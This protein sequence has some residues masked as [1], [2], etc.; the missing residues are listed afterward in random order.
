MDCWKLP[1]QEA[2]SQGDSAMQ[3]PQILFIKIVNYKVESL[4]EWFIEAKQDTLG[5]VL[6][7][8]VQ[9]IVGQKLHSLL[10]VG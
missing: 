9:C 8:Q 6:W 3:R 2:K 1:K 7:V 4:K 10:L 5:L